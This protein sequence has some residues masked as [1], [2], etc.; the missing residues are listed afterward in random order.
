[1]RH[2]LT[3]SKQTRDQAAL[4]QLAAS[5]V[6][7][8]TPREKEV[9]EHLVAGHSNKIIAYELAISPRTVE[10]HRGNLMEKMQARSLSNVIQMALVA[11]VGPPAKR[12]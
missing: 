4:A 7:L 6:A 2:A 3:L 1:V 10:I 11:G 5:R 8:L 12:H 9:L